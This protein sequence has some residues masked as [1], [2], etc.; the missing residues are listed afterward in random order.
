MINQAIHSLDI[1]QWLCGMPK[2]VVAHISNNSLKDVIEV[3]DTA[4]GIF[5]LGNGGNF[6]V[7]ATNAARHCFPVY[8]AFKSGTDVIELSADNLIVNGKF[9]TKENDAPMLGKSEWGSGHSILIREYYS[10]LKEGRH[11]PIDFD[12]AKNSILL[13][14]KMYQSNGTNIDI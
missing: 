10:C 3:E 11:F 13:I 14:I 7:H 6:V 2:S 8:M 9:V 4:F 5:D 1:L 12:E